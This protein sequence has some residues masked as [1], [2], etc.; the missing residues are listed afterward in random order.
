MRDTRSKK[1]LLNGL[2]GLALFLL[3]SNV[4]AAKSKICKSTGSSY[5][6]AGAK[7]IAY[8][9]LEKDP[10]CFSDFLKDNCET[11]SATSKVSNYSFNAKEIGGDCFQN[12]DTKEVSCYMDYEVT[13]DKY[14][15]KKADSGS[16]IGIL[17]N[18]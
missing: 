10:S 18:L 11:A 12:F 6:S 5:S 3:S 16:K 13:C 1:I 8:Q 4:F 7:K 2:M 14:K 9:K 15:S 17:N